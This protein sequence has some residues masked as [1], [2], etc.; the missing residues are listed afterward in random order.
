M[1]CKDDS[2]CRGRATRVAQP[3]LRPFTLGSHLQSSVKYMDG[4]LMCKVTHCLESSDRMGTL[5][6]TLRQDTGGWLSSL[7]CGGPSC[8]QSPRDRGICCSCLTILRLCSFEAA[9]PASADAHYMRTAHQ[10]AQFWA[11]RQAEQ[12]ATTSLRAKA[13]NRS[14]MQVLIVL[15]CHTSR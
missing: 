7:S 1:G 13:V 12:Q 8:Q 6:P 5:K 10:E 15:L 4:N 9:E 14:A 2:A 11:R 3:L